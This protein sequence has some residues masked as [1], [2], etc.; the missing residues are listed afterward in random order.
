MTLAKRLGLLERTVSA[1]LRK[2]QQLESKVLRLESRLRQPD[3]YNSDLDT[4]PADVPSIPRRSKPPRESSPSSVFDSDSDI[5]DVDSIQSTTTDSAATPPPP[6]PLEEN[7]SM[8]EAA[9]SLQKMHQNPLHV[10]TSSNHVPCLPKQSP[11]KSNDRTGE[12]FKPAASLPAE[13]NASD[14]AL[15]KNARTNLTKI[16]TALLHHRHASVLKQSCTIPW[17]TAFLKDHATSDGQNLFDLNSMNE[18]LKCGEYR[19]HMEFKRDFDG[20]KGNFADRNLFVRY[21]K[22]GITQF[23]LED[24]DYE[25]LSA[26]RLETCFTSYWTHYFPEIMGKRRRGRESVSETGVDGKKFRL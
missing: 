8:E 2:I 25:V 3:D 13:T 19:S 15:S 26:E 1:Q 6:S 4:P 21:A 11:K 23:E 16:M 9:A 18:R 20:L 12:L 24:L 22:V 14:H 5:S 10:T 17:I 7:M